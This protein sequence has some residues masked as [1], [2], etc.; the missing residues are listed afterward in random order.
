MEND[1]ATFSTGISIN[2]PLRVELFLDQSNVRQS[3][4]EGKVRILTDQG[5]PLGPGVNSMYK[6]DE[7]IVSKPVVG[8][9]CFI[10]HIVRRYLTATHEKTA[11]GI[12]IQ[13][14]ELLTGLMK[15]MVYSLVFLKQLCCVCGDEMLHPRPCSP[16]LP[17]P[18]TKNLC[19]ALFEQWMVVSPPKRL[20]L[21][22][23][24]DSLKNEFKPH[25]DADMA[26]LNS[27]GVSRTDVFCYEQNFLALRTAQIRIE[28]TNSWVEVLEPDDASKG[29]EKFS[30][31]MQEYGK[32]TNEKAKGKWFEN[33]R[34]KVIEK[35]Y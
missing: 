29:T 14:E 8:L 21:V 13:A 11:E 33:Q 5:L 10:P 3:L 35:V 26:A 23:V 2:D 19:R 16:L 30:G 7:L 9:S 4:L 28:A 6:D 12:I 17:K 1:I 24:T 18:C 20:A 27:L 15:Q 22:S 25:S 31:K 32:T 34:S